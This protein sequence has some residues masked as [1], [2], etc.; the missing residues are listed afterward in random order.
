M[1]IFKKIK[2]ALKFE[3][4]NVKGI[5]KKIA[6]NPQRLLVGAV[7]PIGTKIAN[8][9]LGTKWKPA[10]NQL[11]GA[12]NETF[13]E[14]KAKGMEVGLAKSLHTA[15]VVIAAYY[16][17]GG[18][19]AGIGGGGSG[20]AGAGAGGL[21]AVGSGAYA[22]SAL[23]GAGFTG[24]VAPI[25]TTAVGSAAVP[26][27]G[28]AAQASTGAVAP[29]ASGGVAAAPAAAAAAPT[30]SAA[31]GAGGLLS[32]AASVGSDIY[33]AASSDA[34]KM[35]IGTALQGY[36]AG[37]QQQAQQNYDAK[38]RRAFTPEEL[39]QMNAGGGASASASGGSGGY[40]DRARRVSDFLGER[41]GP[42]DP[43]AVAGYA[44]GEF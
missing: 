28:I 27:A 16:A 2:K 15:A 18:S 12:T 21:D 32:K 43:A 8:T 17:A 3:V 9:V 41:G 5:I 30:T 6:K 11:G 19:I 42:V 20:A 44:R 39:A 25:S 29:V 23:T 38:Y 13:A 33:K 14:A 34:G 36:A 24:T 10:V 37:K 4:F 22:N 1:G 35:I 40:L 31:S 26:V 7:D